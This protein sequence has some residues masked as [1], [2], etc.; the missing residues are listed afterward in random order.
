MWFGPSER[1]TQH[2][3]EN[4]VVLL[5]PGLAHVSLGL[6]FFLHPWK[7]AHPSLL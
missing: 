4:G 3:Q 6:S 2:P 1:N 5:K 7:G